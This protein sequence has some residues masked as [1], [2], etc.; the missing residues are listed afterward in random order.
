VEAAA[1]QAILVVLA[2]LVPGWK[3]LLLLE[4]LQV[5]LFQLVE[6]VLLDHPHRTH[7]LVVME[8]VCRVVLPS[9]QEL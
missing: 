4:T 2:V 8:Q 9:Q 1:A 3:E 5:F 6:V 7:L